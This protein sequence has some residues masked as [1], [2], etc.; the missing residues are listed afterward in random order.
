MPTLSEDKKLVWLGLKQPKQDQS[1][2]EKTVQ[3]LEEHVGDFSTYQTEVDE[4]L[5]SLSEHET[6]LINQGFETEDAESFTSKIENAYNTWDDYRSFVVADIN[7]YEGLKNGFGTTSA[8][9]GESQTESGEPASG[10]RVHD[11]GGITY[12]GVQVPAGTVEV[13]GN[14]VEFSQQDPP[15]DAEAVFEYSNLQVSN[16]IPTTFETI[17]VS[18]DISNTGNREGTAYV[19]LLEDGAV[20]AEQQVQVAAGA[21]ETVTFSWFSSE[22]KSVELTIDGLEPE[23]VSVIPAGLLFI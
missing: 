17:D 11:D 9:V 10:I 6:Y 12:A 22:L 21:T 16:T 8:F 1:V 7:S 19:Q 2:I 13:F 14:R 4:N 5:T 23:L 18:A 3:L 20:Y 15:D